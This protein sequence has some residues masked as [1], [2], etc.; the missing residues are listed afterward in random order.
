M[1]RQG[2][3]CTHGHSDAV[4]RSHRW[5]TAGLEVVSSGAGVWCFSSPEDVAWCS[6]GARARREQVGEHVAGVVRRGVVHVQVPDQADRA[7]AHAIRPPRARGRR[8]RTRRSPPGGREVEDDDVR[9]DLRGVEHAG[10]A[11]ATPPRRGGRGRGRPRAARRDG[12]ARTGRRRRGCRPGAS[13]RRTACARPGPRR[14]APRRADEHDPTGAPSPLDRHTETVSTPGR[15]RQRHPGRDVGVPEPGAVEVHGDPEIARLRARR[16]CST[17]CTVPPPKLCVFST[18]RGPC[19]TR[20]GPASGASAPARVGGAD[21]PAPAT[22]VRVEMPERARPPELGPHHVRQAVA[23][24]FL[25]GPGEQPDAEHVRHRAGR[26][27]SPASWP[28]SSA[29]C[30]SSALTSGPRRRRRPR[31]PPRPSRRASRPSA[32]SGCRAQ[33]GADGRGRHRRPARASRRR[34]R[35]SPATAGGSAAGRRASRSGSRGRPRRSA[36]RRRGTR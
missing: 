31:P 4:L 22:Q 19:D 5:R 20:Y 35:P 36:R 2:E 29:T 10:S 30:A 11:S 27:N 24:Q 6:G 26:A 23:E 3:V 17:G 9:L 32:G 21:R 8:R 7:R 13:R 12:P 15:T 28:S 14:S 18:A 34:G 33:V 1:S 25:A 16:S